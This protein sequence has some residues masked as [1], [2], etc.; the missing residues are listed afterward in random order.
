MQGG[1][2]EEV[3]LDAEA[4]DFR[5]VVGVELL[6]APESVATAHAS[7]RTIWTR[8]ASCSQMP[9]CLASSMS[10]TKVACARAALIASETVRAKEVRIC[11][12]PGGD[13]RLTQAATSLEV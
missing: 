4:V 11:A 9:M 13:P 6:M 8:D 12:F 5:S 1:A 7:A 3:A 2:A 10:R